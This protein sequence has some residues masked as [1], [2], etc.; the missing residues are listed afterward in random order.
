MQEEK[1][2]VWLFEATWLDL[3]PS[4]S[5]KS[6]DTAAHVSDKAAALEAFFNKRPVSV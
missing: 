2:A 3:Y 6:K 1:R 4:V 5:N